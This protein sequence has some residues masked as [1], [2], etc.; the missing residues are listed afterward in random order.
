M[1]GV[2]IEGSGAS[3]MAKIVFGQRISMEGFLVKGGTTVIDS[4]RRLHC[5]FLNLALR[6]VAMFSSPSFS[7]MMGSTTSSTSVSGSVLVADRSTSI[8]GSVLV[9][10]DED[11]E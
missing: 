9:V 6:F 5:L 11:V 2:A 3:A 10:E 8:S 4:D 1:P 7:Q